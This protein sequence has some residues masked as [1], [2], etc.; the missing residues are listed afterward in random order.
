MLAIVSLDV[1]EAENPMRTFKIHQVD[2]FTDVLF[3]G[4]PTA[5]V[6]GAERLTE[7]E[8][9]NIAR[10]MNLSETVFMF[11]SNN[12]HVRLRYFT[13]PGDEI[14]FCGHATLGALAVIS[15]EGLYGVG[16]GENATLQV[17]TNA[18][19]LAMEVDYSKSSSPRFVFEAPKI[20]MVK[21]KCTLDEVMSA[22]NIPSTHVDLS[23]PL[24][25][26]KTNNYLFFSVPS[27]QKLGEIDI[28]VRSAIEFARADRYVVYCAIALEAIDKANDIHCR[29]FAPLVGVPEDPFTGSM[30]GGVCGYL[31]ANE[32]IPASRE[33]IRCEQGHFIKR[34][35]L[36][37]M[38]ILRGETLRA[39]LAASAVHVFQTE[40]TIP[41]S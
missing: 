35:G 16:K 31:V 17:E 30:Y 8:M 6:R 39:R 3:G 25:L 12:A 38:E 28:D 19:V 11:P 2:S 15:R 26:E 33:R 7:T 41:N 22:L 34:P 20:E 1:M 10:E 23:K 36:V 5:V 32:M 40:M 37:E 24:L 4:N 13:P 18:G 21:P 14:R 27:L 29:G 9:K